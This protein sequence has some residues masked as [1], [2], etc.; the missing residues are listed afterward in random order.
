M[1]NV[2]GADR[3][4]RAILGL[5]LIV[6]PFTPF[7]APLFAAWGLWKFALLAIGLVMAGTAAFR[8]CPLYTLI[9]LNTCRVERR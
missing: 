3:M 7:A 6:A 8:F 5:V 9:G 4:V 1:A 2:G